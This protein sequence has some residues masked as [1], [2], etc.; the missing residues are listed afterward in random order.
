MS[1]SSN[2]TTRISKS[3]GLMRAG[4]LPLLQELVAELILCPQRPTELFR[5][6]LLKAK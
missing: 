6:L 5:R 1:K 3:G 2:E 4:N